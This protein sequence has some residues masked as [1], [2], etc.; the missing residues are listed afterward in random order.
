MTDLARAR[1]WIAQDP[2]PDTRAELAGLVER[3][4]RGEA[5]ALADLDSRFG[6][7]LEFGTAG[8]R[9]AL[10]AGP[11]RM[12]RVVVMRA[13][14]GIAAWLGAGPGHVVVG[15]DA[16][17]RSADFARD[18]AAVLTGAGHRVSLMPGPLPTPVLAF[19]V[20]DLGADAGIMVTASHNPPRDN[21]Y[22]VYAGAAKA[23]GAADAGTQIVS[24]AD[25]EISAAIDAVGPV[26]E[27]PLGEGW[28]VLGEE[29][30]ERYLDAV[31]ALVPGGDRDLAT[32][33]TAMHGVGGR[34]LL[35]AMERAGFPRPSVVA[36]QFEPD[37]DFPTVDFPNP[38]EPGAMDMALATGAADRSDLVIANDPDADRLALAVPGHG[39][40]TG[41]EVGGLL[42]E[43]VLDHT[44]GSDR[45]VAASIVSSSLLGKIARDRGVHY[46]ETLTGFKWLARAGGP[47][48]RR[49]FAFEEALGYCVGADGGRPVADKDGISAA[50]VAAA[51]AARAKR[52]GATLLDLLDD[53]ARR[54][55]LHLSDQLSVRV[56]DLT[57]ISA[58]MRRL[59]AEPPAAFGP[60]RVVGVDDFAAGHAGLPPTDALRFRLEGRGR[61]TLRPSGTEP[62]LKAYVEVVLD[63]DGDVAAT[64]ALGSDLLAELMAS[65]TAAVG[66]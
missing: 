62:K 34:V 66:G 25:A 10:G 31:T 29:A 35:A 28:T 65:V 41:N 13:A 57:V 8:L 55:G 39:L 18:S 43:Y 59:R 21:G 45:V 4:G 7:R 50:L 52:E 27:L 2:D 6:A 24:P 49:V 60:L 9:G 42:A 20:R 56:E 51:L 63:V 36:A 32:T 16:R 3:A 38:E 33:Y 53:Q 47:G 58:A 54:Y 40:L 46:E 23:G 61:V 5:D 48:Q 26:D 19:A 12:N 1:R 15:Y 30:V 44:S 37:P 64:R 22:K 14:A 11:N 17:H